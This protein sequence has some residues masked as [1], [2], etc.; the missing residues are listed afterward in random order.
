MKNGEWVEVAEY[1]AVVRDPDNQAFDGTDIY[2]YRDMPEEFGTFLKGVGWHH[3]G[4]KPYPLGT[5]TGNESVPGR[6]IVVHK[7]DRC[8][9]SRC[10]NDKHE[11]DQHVDLTGTSYTREKPSE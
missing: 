11:G 1:T 3:T 2:W 7:W 5:W 4:D 8:W 9:H 6:S 10:V